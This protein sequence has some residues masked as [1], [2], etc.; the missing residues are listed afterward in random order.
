M[1][2][3]KESLVELITQTSANLPPDVRKG[4]ALSTVAAFLSG[5]CPIAPG[6]SPEG[7]RKLLAGKAEP[8]RTSGGKA[9]R[10]VENL[11]RLRPFIPIIS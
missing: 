1:E 3:L 5:L 10:E 11:K 4:F 6:H 2:F 9:A 7:L 8:F